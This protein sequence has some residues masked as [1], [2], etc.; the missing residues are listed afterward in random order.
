MLQ[1]THSIKYIRNIFC[2]Y[3]LFCRFTF[4]AEFVPLFLQLLIFL[5]VNDCETSEMKMAWME[6]NTQ[7]KV[8]HE[9]R[10]WLLNV[11]QL[12]RND[13]VLWFLTNLA[14]QAAKKR[15]A[16]EIERGRSMWSEAPWAVL[17]LVKAMG[18]LQSGSFPVLIKLFR[19]PTASRSPAKVHLVWCTE[20]WINKCLS[21]CPLIRC[22][23]PPSEKSFADKKLNQLAVT[24]LGREE[25]QSLINDGNS[26]QG[27]VESCLM[28]SLKA[29]V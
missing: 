1:S 12:A 28:S 10:I 11:T 22:V 16:S 6:A 14:A 9:V 27:S 20:M 7:L 18:T 24:A 26:Q 4:T 2:W 25:E 13:C 19:S 5:K 8:L 21:R 29:E 3:D 15:I 23:R 17:F